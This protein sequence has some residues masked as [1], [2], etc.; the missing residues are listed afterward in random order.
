[1]RHDR[2]PNDLTRWLTSVVNNFNVKGS[3]CGLVCGFGIHNVTVPID[4][5]VVSAFSLSDCDEQYAHREK[6]LL[7]RM[8]RAYQILLQLYIY[9]GSGDYES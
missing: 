1:M 9:I 3:K 6:L 8:S 7:C 2:G 4:Y 5:I